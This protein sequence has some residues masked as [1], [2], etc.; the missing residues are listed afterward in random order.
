MTK[1][2]FRQAVLISGR[3]SRLLA[4]NPLGYRAVAGNI[5]GLRDCLIAGHEM[6]SVSRKVDSGELVGPG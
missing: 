1:I 3:P 4:G 6:D 2:D 5:N